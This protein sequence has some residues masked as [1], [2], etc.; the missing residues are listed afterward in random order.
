V[1]FCLVFL[2]ACLILYQPAFAQKGVTPDRIPF[3]QADDRF[4]VI[5][6]SHSQAKAATSRIDPTRLQAEAKELFELLQS[7]QP[8]MHFI[9]N[10]LLPKDTVEKLRR[11]EKLSKHLRGELSQ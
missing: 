5:L 2:L 7:L 9:Q 11:I 3:P 1:K 8:D 6:Q 10:G 4:E